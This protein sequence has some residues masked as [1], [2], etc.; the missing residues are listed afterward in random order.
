M[1]VIHAE[2]ELVLSTSALE[3]YVH[4]ALHMMQDTDGK[5]VL[6]KSMAESMSV[7][8]NRARLALD[9]LNAAKDAE[10]A[11]SALAEMPDRPRVIPM[12]PRLI[13]MGTVSDGG[14]AA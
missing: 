7:A 9:N 8:A 1:S 14:H 12:R 6:P 2:L 3:S 4:T 13:S 10:R 11:R 5:V